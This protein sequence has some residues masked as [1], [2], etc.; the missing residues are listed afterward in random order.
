VSVLPTPLIAVVGAVVAPPRHA[1]L[2]GRIA[3][4]A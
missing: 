2:M 3:A 1:G 4:F